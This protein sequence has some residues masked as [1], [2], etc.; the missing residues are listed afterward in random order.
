M[1]DIQR[2]LLARDD[3]DFASREAA[4][5][6]ARLLD[7]GCAI[8]TIADAFVAAGLG[9]LA[10]NPNTTDAVEAFAALYAGIRGLADGH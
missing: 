2:A 6:A 8:D 4:A 9:L 7:N 10:A 5:L 1:T 3:L